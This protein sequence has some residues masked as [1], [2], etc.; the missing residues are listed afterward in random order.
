MNNDNIPEIIQRLM[1]WDD[2]YT[3][4][5]ELVTDAVYDVTR[6]QAFN[7]YPQNEYFK[8]V[9]SEVRGGKIPLPYTMGSLDQIYE[10]QVDDYAEDKLSG[11][12]DQRVVVSNKLDGV[13][14]MIVYRN[15]ELE[16]AYSRGD[17]V[18]G[19]DITR[20]IKN[21]RNVPKKVSTYEYLVVRGEAIM[22]NP[23]FDSLYKG[24]KKTARAMVSGAMNASETLQTVL[25]NIDFIS[26]EIVDTNEGVIASKLKQ[27][28]VL[29]KDF[30]VVPYDVFEVK[31]VTDKKLI[32]HLEKVR[33]LTDYELDGLVVT[34]EDVNAHDARKGSSLNPTHSIKFKK[35][36]KGSYKETKVV[37]VHY[38]VGKS[39]FHKPRIEIEPVELFGTTVTY[40]TGHNANRIEELGIGVGAVITVTK[41]GQVIPYL[42][43]CEKPTKPLLPEG[44]GVEWEWNETHKE[45]LVRNLDAHPDVRFE[46]LLS[47]FTTLD[48]PGLKEASLREIL[49]YVQ[50]KN[51]TFDSLLNCVVR[52]DKK[53]WENVIGSNGNKI[54]DALQKK[55][56]NLDK[57][58][59]LGALPYL[60][61]GFG[62]RKSKKL[63]GQLDGRDI[64]SLDAETIASMEGFNKT[65]N[66][67]VNGLPKAQQLWESWVNDNI[68]TEAVK[69]QIGSKLT[70]INAVFTGVRD[71]SLQSLIE[72]EGGKV[73]SGVSKNTTHLVAKD[74]SGSSDKLKK[75]RDMG[76]DVLSLDDFRTYVMDVMNGTVKA[77]KTVSLKP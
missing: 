35:L 11:S 2:A 70:S 50:H 77:K 18:Q 27:L 24:Q 32:E 71:K 54:H 42:V 36:P 73:G 20:H 1:L 47:F 4:G 31:D 60:G 7:L 65:A 29:S 48:I 59:F 75:A 63:V 43:R 12:D 56:K 25:D 44:Y 55:L 51:E 58:T 66:T 30:E 49:D 45:A 41:S 28:E 15:G 76:I 64:W 5:E 16:I 46:Q 22:K 53:D 3:N 52:L 34:T 33:V 10:G 19:A 14:I 13:S 62:V 68:I 37:N 26:Y 17:G 9:G 40:V 61:F 57:E 74:V 67:I 39:G 38:N 23:V 21:L 8:R 72:S 6:L 69:A